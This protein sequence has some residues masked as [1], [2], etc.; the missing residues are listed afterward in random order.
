MQ[1]LVRKLWQLRQHNKKAEW[2]SSMAKELEGLEVGLKMKVHMDSLGTTLKMSN[3][4]TPGHDGIY[5][6]W[7]KKCTSIHDIQ[8]LAKNR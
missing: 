4:K 3:K 8:V 1:F 2:I 6:L 5:G 7:F